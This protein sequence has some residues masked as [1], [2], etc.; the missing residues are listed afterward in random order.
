MQSNA[1]AMTTLC[2]LLSCGPKQSKLT[3]TTAYQAQRHL[4]VWQ[5]PL[6][7]GQLGGASSAS[8]QRAT[9]G[10]RRP[11]ARKSILKARTLR[12]CDWFEFSATSTTSILCLLVLFYV[13]RSSRSNQGRQSEPRCFDFE[14]HAFPCAIRRQFRQPRGRTQ[15]IKKKTGQS[16]S[17]DSSVGGNQACSKSDQT[18][19]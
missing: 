16:T 17:D 13:V 14:F 6:V 4:L 10:G 12:C 11:S 18:S 7:A 9:A 3:L 8:A 1:A 5:H 2:A 19:H 15:R